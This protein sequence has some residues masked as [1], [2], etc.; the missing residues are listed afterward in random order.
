MLDASVEQR[1]FQDLIQ[2]YNSM[3]GN[4]NKLM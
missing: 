4:Y 3:K 1:K 2:N